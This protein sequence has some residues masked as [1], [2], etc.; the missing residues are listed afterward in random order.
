MTLLPETTVGALIFNEEGK[1]FLMKSFKW[2]DMYCIPGGHVE[3]GE[4]LTQAVRRE[5]KEETNLEIHDVKFHAIQD[6]IFSDNFH[7]KKHFI[8]ID[9]TCNAIPGKIDLNDE[10]SEFIWVDL[11]DLDRY[12]IEPYTLKTIMLYTDSENKSRYIE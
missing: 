8:F 11:H 5:V 3:T 2:K 6:C 9:F 4:T 10:A 12:P 7:S 1:L